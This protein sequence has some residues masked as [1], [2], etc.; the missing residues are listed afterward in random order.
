MCA[1]GR[2]LLAYGTAIV[3][4]LGCLSPHDNYLRDL[5]VLCHHVTN[6]L[7]AECLEGRTAT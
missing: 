3:Q 6:D 5:Y 4:V 1:R 2:L 7:K